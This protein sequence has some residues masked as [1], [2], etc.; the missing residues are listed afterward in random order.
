MTAVS[1]PP[2]GTEERNGSREHPAEP[3]RIRVLIVAAYA[4]AR[5]ALH[6]QL[7]DAADITI[8]GEVPD[9]AEME[10][11]LPE[12]RPDV[13]L[14]DYT[15]SDTAR[16]PAVLADG[17]A[18]LVVL[19]DADED[20]RQI[21]TASLPGWAFLLREAEGEEIEAAIRAVAAG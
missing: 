9:S 7:A 19:G 16:L 3:R 11:L 20:F 15:D 8:L 4:S 2:P 17:N 14:F 21:A 1:A 18:G 13:V 5:A 10:R 12:V 6:A